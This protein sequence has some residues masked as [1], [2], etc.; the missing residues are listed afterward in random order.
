MDISLSSRLDALDALDLD[1][2]LALLRRPAPAEP[3]S[4]EALRQP[5]AVAVAVAPNTP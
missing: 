2:L 4:L 5:L 3:H 1:D